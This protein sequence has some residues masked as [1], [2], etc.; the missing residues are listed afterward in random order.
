MRLSACLVILAILSASEIAEAFAGTSG[1]RAERVRGRA[2][3]IRRDKLIRITS[4]VS[5]R[6]G[7][8]V[9][10]GADSSIRV[11]SGPL[12]VDL[13]E[14]SLL[15]VTSQGIKLRYGAFRSL[16]KAS[17]TDH[18][19]RKWHFPSGVAE[20]QPQSQQ[21]EFVIVIMRNE[22]ALNELFGGTRP[23]PPKFAEV[24]RLGARQEGITWI[25]ALSGAIHVKPNATERVLLRTSETLKIQGKSG[26][27][28]ALPVSAAE[29]S[30]IRDA[31][32]FSQ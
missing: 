5:L 1:T 11:I 32:G 6:A 12:E 29:L 16:V 27:F 24:K 18:H 8:W 17:A 14:E 9:D 7:D 23:K 15:E 22:K 30:I 25:A 19:T 3:V 28:A 26:D 2:F 4:E 31:L 10:T 13:A 20:T 21:G